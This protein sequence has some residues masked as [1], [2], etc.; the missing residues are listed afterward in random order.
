VVCIGK[1]FESAVL[2]TA[3]LVD[4]GVKNIQA[5]ANSEIEK[6]ILHRVGAQEVFFVERA[7]GEIIAKRFSTPSL[8]DDMELGD[9]Y[10]VYNFKAE[11]S[12]VGKTLR[13]LQLPAR[14]SIQVVGLRSDSTHT[15]ETP[16]PDRRVESNDT[17]VLIGKKE[18]LERFSNSV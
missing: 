10:S 18:D 17:L 3:H 15:L 9:G 12:L 4:L 14:F 5:R 13:E 1:E 2:V 16:T 11:G 7:M 8:V 6:R